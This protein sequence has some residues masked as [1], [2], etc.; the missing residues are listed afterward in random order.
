MYHHFHGV[1]QLGQG[2]EKRRVVDGSVVLIS[3]T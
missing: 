2:E 1:D 3:P